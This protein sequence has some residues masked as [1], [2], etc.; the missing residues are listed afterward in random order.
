MVPVP[1]TTALVKFNKLLLSVLQGEEG[2]SLFG[3]TLEQDM[4]TILM[5]AYHRVPKAFL[6]LGGKFNVN[7]RCRFRSG[8]KTL[9]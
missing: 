5:I 6:D 7:P 1:R 8:T 2:N 9:L 4:L 3:K